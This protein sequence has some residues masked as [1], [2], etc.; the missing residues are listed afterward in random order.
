MRCLSYSQKN[1]LWLFLQIVFFGDKLHEISKP[2]TWE[3]NII[4]LLSAEFAHRVIKIKTH[5]LGLLFVASLP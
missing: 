4:I 1:R 3:K 5:I 2:I